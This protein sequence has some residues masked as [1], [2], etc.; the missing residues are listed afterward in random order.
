M[1]FLYVLI[2]YTPVLIDSRQ[3][4]TLFRV[5]SWLSGWWK[6]MKISKKTEDQLVPHIQHGNDSTAIKGCWVLYAGLYCHFIFMWFQLV[7]T[8]KPPN[9]RWFNQHYLRWDIGFAVSPLSCQYTKP[10]IPV[11]WK[12][13]ILRVEGKVSSNQKNSKPNWLVVWNIFLFS[14]ILGIIIPID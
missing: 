10:G 4:Q 7:P 11:V 5:G 8:K 14:H 2:V 3:S 12:S 1:W 6:S 13:A 9:C